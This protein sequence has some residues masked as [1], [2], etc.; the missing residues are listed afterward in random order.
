MDPRRTRDGILMPL[1]L[2]PTSPA[3]IAR[4]ELRPRPPRRRLRH[5]TPI[6]STIIV[7]FRQWENT[8]ALTHQLDSSDSMRAGQAEVVLIDNDSE[9]QPLRRCVRYWP[10]VTL[11]CFGRNRGFA[12][13]VNEGCRRA[14]GQ[15]LLLLN[16]DVRVPEEFL[17]AVLASA[18][19]IVAADPKAGII[20]FQLR[21]DDETRQGSSGPEPTLGNVMAGL[22]RP[23]SRRR[24]Q[25]IAG[26]QRRAVEWVTGC[27]LLVRRECWEQLG[28]FDE[29]Y[30]LYYEDVD[31]CS[32]ARDAG[33]S[34]WYDPTV[35][36]THFRP[37]HTRRVSAALRLMTRHALLTYAAKHWPRW[38]FRLLGGLVWSEAVLR[39]TIAA[40]RG[41]FDAAGH[42]A[43]LRTLACDL[44][45]G[46][47]LRARHHLLRSARTL[48]R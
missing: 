46:R 48:E 6:I 8:V 47:G 26:R 7:N 13:A 35:R 15:W 41:H 29:D 12:R 25:P 17:D 1:A 36:V 32:R 39:Q 11:R 16:P 5:R 30:F 40:V 43:R 42:F 31:L 38:Q 2:T 19:R 24:C 10:G 23:R 3:P 22:L 28:G 4:A 14:R 34:V 44:I 21:H 9:A 20:G 37:L 33:W 27:C 18:E 45:R